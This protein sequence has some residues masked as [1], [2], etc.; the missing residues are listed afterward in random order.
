[1]NPILH[2]SR[3]AKTVRT[4]VPYGISMQG[5]Q[6]LLPKHSKRR[7]KKMVKALNTYI[8]TSLYV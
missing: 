3:L 5:L 6:R 8:N 7:I 1:M 2:S 4:A